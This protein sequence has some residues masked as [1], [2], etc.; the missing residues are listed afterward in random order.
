MNISRYIKGKGARA[1]FLA[2]FAVAAPACAP[3]FAGGPGSAGMQ[4][5]K[6]DMSPR[7][8]GMGGAFVAV[9][10]DIYSMDYNPAGLGQLYIPEASA[11]Y[12][13]GFDDSKLQHFSFGMPLPFLGLARLQK[14]GAGIS[15]LLSD[16]GRFNY[17]HINPDGTL[18][19]RSYD[20]QKDMVISFGY[21]EKVYSNEVNLE[22]YKAQIE[23]YLGM[24]AKY[25]KSTLLKDYPAS[26][27]AFDAG[28]LMM[29]PRLGISLGA[30]IA[31]YGGGLKYDTEITKLPSILRL[32]ASW[33]RP[34][35]MDQSLL[36]T[37]EADF[38]TTE[39]LKSLRAGLEYHFQNIFNLRAGYRGGED[40]KGFTMGLG[41][42]YDDMSLDFAMGIGNEVYNASQVAFSYKFSGITIKEYRKKTA[43]KDP[44]FQQATP[45]KAKQQSSQSRKPA[46]PPEKKKDSDFFWIY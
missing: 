7:A 31:N 13:S 33:Q 1:A 22:G 40:N 41:V 34:T 24:N 18:F 8:A 4:V 9:A 16:A 45:A 38:Y 5:L 35:V 17:Q 37:G 15:I 43:F 28:W 36:I 10:D 14:P 46:A 27:A 19:T 42:H 3:L 32:G 20:A 29:E 12:Q 2:A 44:E 25:V 11:M 30:S 6:T 26:S 39:A 23:Q 21:G